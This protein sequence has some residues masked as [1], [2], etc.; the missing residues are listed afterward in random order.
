MTDI[1]KSAAVVLV[2]Y[3]VRCAKEASSGAERRYLKMMLEAL[4]LLR[5][6]QKGEL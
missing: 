5:E 6:A 2:D 1:E 3:L 4:A